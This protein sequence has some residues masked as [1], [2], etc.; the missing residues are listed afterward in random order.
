MN[1]SKT[2]GEPMDNEKEKEPDQVLHSPNPYEGF[3]SN[4][5]PH[6]TQERGGVW[7]P[8]EVHRFFLYAQLLHK[9]QVPWLLS[10]YQHLIYQEFK[11]YLKLIYIQGKHMV[12]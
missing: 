8:L 3:P 7:L 1:V 11:I 4:Y 9:F 2:L 10:G 6:S 12:Q 5:S